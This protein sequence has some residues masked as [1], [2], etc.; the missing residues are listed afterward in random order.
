MWST[1]LIDIVCKK[2]KGKVYS[3]TESFANKIEKNDQTTTEK[4][5]DK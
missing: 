1:E 3:N 4:K 2:K 5:N